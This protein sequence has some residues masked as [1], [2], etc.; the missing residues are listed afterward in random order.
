MR[1]N[2]MPPNAGVRKGE[3]GETAAGAAVTLLVLAA[4]LTLFV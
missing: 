2:M 4:I 1:P 3:I